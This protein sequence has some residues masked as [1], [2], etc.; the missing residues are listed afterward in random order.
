MPYI[1]I[2]F[3]GQATAGGYLKVDGG[4]QIELS[5]DMMIEV[6]VGTH[7]LEFSSKSSVERGISNLNVA[8]GNYRTAAW[9]E[10]DAVDGKITE[11]FPENGVMLF[12]VVS[13][14]AGHIMDLPTYSI[15][16]VPDERYQ[17]LTN[18]YNERIAAMEEEYEQEKSTR[19]IEFLL[20]FFLGA[21]GAHKFYRK[22]F[23][24]G[25]LYLLTGGIFGIG[26]LIDTFKLL[27]KVLFK[28]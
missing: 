12:T 18:I 22:Q 16:S 24:M 26:W 13:D 6:S 9:A 2:D 27:F 11:R 10:K 19:G 3:Q 8:V 15:E 25:I 5:D 7:Y 17:E 20:C 21:L 14:S 28:K 4:Q 23:G 1:I